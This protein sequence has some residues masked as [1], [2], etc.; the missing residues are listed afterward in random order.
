MGSGSC[1]LK[2]NPEKMLRCCDLHSEFTAAD[3]EQPKYKSQRFPLSTGDG[4]NTETFRRLKVFL[5][6]L[7]IYVSDYFQKLDD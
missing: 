6:L 2:V 5:F 1:Y 7:N 3:L 4:I